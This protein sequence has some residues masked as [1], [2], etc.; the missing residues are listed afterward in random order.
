MTQSLTIGR[1]AAA[2]G[3]NAETVRYYEKAGMLNPPARTN[4]NYRSYGNDDLARLR[5]IRRTRE[6]GFSLDVVR[7]LLDLARE[8]DN[9]CCKV[10]ALAQQQLEDI[11]RKIA[12]LNALQ[13]ELSR[14]IKGCKGGSVRDCQILEAFSPAG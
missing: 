1:L 11:E 10:D 7:T 6:L 12:D 5:F 2:A 3:T 14:V 9:D 13:R 4:S 8:G